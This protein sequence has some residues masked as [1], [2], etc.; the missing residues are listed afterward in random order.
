MIYW[1]VLENTAKGDD[2]NPQIYKG[3]C[4]PCTAHAG[5]KMAQFLE[6]PLY[7]DLIDNFMLQKYLHRGEGD[8]TFN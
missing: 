6:S 1:H 4:R 8:Y 3:D 2:I 5:I 7:T